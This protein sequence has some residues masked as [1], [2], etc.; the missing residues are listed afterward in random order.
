M[1]YSPD[2]RRKV[3]GFLFR[4]DGIFFSS[5]F[6]CAWRVHIRCRNLTSLEHFSACY[7]TSFSGDVSRLGQGSTL[8]ENKQECTFSSVD[9]VVSVGFPLSGGFLSSSRSSVG[10]PLICRAVSFRPRV[11]AG[12]CLSW[13]HHFR[14]RRV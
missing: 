1:S 5:E 6:G 11:D 3:R 7:L 10:V 13:L 12:E 9:R 2:R 4:E 8:A 14:F